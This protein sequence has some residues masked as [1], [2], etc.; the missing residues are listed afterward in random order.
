MLEQT[1]INMNETTQHKLVKVL[2]DGRKS[3]YLC[4][5]EKYFGNLDHVVDTKQ[6]WPIHEGHNAR[7]HLQDFMASKGFV[8]E[9]FSYIEDG[10]LFPSKFSDVEYG[11]NKY[12]SCIEDGTFF[13]CKKDDPKVTFLLTSRM[14]RYDRTY[15]I[16]IT[17]LEE[18]VKLS[19]DLI[20]EFREYIVDHNI[21]RKQKLHGDLSFIKQ[22]I[23]YSWDDLLLDPDT[24]NLLQQNLL[25]V[26]DKREVYAKLGITTKRGIILSGDP[27]TGKTMVGKILS[28][29]LTDWSFLWISPGDLQRIETLRTYCQLAKI[30]APTILFLEDLDLHFKD[31]DVNASSSMLGELMNQ[32]DGIDD[33][34]NIVVI[35]TTNKPGDLEAALAKRPGRFDKVIKFDKPS[36]ATVKK[37]YER[38]SKDRLGEVDWDKVLVASKGLTGA[39][40]KEVL[41][42]AMLKLIDNS[43]FDASKP[44]KLSTK[45]ILDGIKA[46]KNKDF[47][48]PT[49]GFSP[50][51][52]AAFAPN[53]D[54]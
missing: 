20:R 34:S 2:R 22:D 27:G 33:I 17:C 52:R 21:Y 24:F 6:E 53:A 23:K 26:L 38:F 18:Q 46:S 25:T 44:I 47:S 3:D 30:I 51:E 8:L 45:D 1:K 37:M 7:F 19:E 16:G 31:R 13:V 4:K 35:G 41:N 15:E 5:I 49:V 28:S 14:A 39:Q 42:Q 11:P 12:K 10:T 54:Y 48:S 32:L 9:L 40:I 50:L 43:K 36:E 29:T